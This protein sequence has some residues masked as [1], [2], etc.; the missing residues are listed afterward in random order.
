MLRIDREA[1]RNAL[2]RA[3]QDSLLR[4]LEALHGKV[5]VIVLRGT[6]ASFYAGPDLKER[7]AEIAADQV[8]TA[9]SEAI[10]I[11]MAL[12]KHPAIVIAAV[13]GFELGQGLTLR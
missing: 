12:R 9:G 5:Q 4:G 11:N 13:N 1:K 3:T 2:D 6:G 8:D 7:E 10:E